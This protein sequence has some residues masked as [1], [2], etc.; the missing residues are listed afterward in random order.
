MSAIVLLCY[1]PNH[2]MIVFYQKFHQLNY[3]VYILVDDNN[4]KAEYLNGVT[5]IQIEDHICS[6]H[7]FY[8]LNPAIEKS[9]KCSAWDKAVYFFSTSETS[10]EN[11]WFIE[12]DVFIPTHEAII[13]IDNKYSCADIISSKNVINYSGELESWVWW[14]FIP[15]NALPLPW[16]SSM[17][18]AVRLSKTALRAT[19]DLIHNRRSAMHG[20]KLLMLLNKF[21]F[22][23]SKKCLNNWKIRYFQYRKFPFIEFLFHTVALHNN[24]KIVSAEELSGIIW[25]KEWTDSEMNN[26]GLYHPIK[27]KDSHQ[28]LRLKMKS[29]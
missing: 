25:R 12:D 24:L 17:V 6:E 18:C 23:F 5:F 22:K 11:V 1:Q 9:S 8:N 10:H 20:D 7:G 16:A 3:D 4:W 15:K 28:F 2:E 19:G 26:L 14:Q 27:D 13:N 21:L 29:K